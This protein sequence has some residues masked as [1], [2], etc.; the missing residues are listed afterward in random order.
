VDN[1]SVHLPGEHPAIGGEDLWPSGRRCGRRRPIIVFSNDNDVI[2]G[3]RYRS[4][5][6]SQ[7]RRHGGTTFGG[8]TSIDV[9]TLPCSSPAAN[10]VGI[11]GRMLL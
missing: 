6:P 9:R 3:E 8:E 5:K 11:F 1:R 2:F 4:L 10:L 7:S